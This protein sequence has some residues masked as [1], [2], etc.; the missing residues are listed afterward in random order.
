LNHGFNFASILRAL[1]EPFCEKETYS[2]LL[3]S[4]TAL[5]E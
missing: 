1:S 5:Q 3:I 2:A 4:I